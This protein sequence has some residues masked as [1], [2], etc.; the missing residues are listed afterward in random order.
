M[1]KVGDIVKTSF[2]E[3]KEIEAL[4]SVKIGLGSVRPSVVGIGASCVSQLKKRNLEDYIDTGG[5]SIPT[6]VTIVEITSKT[7]VKVQD[8][9]E[10]THEKHI[11]ELEPV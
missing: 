2:S 9:F 8:I 11:D 10:K 3:S 7:K 1:F 4:T 6:V 5:Y